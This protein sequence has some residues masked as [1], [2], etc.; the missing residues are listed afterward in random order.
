MT[1]IRQ[2]YITSKRDAANTLHKIYDKNS[3]IECKLVDYDL[4]YIVRDALKIR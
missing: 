1:T 2:N 3:I 4:N